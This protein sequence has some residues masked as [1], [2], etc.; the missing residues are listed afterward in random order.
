VYSRK[1]VLD[2]F[3]LQRFSRGDLLSNKGGFL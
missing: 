3:D 2:N 1:N